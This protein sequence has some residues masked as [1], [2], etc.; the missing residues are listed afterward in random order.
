M[1]VQIGFIGAGSIA[2]THAEALAPLDVDIVAVADVDTETRSAFAEE[3]D[4]GATYEDYQRMLDEEALDGG[5]V[6]VPNHL[7]ADCAVACLEAGIH[8]FVE[9]PLAHT[10]EAGRRIA[11]AEASS[12]ATVFVGFT[13]TFKPTVESVKRR[14][15]DDEFGDIYDVGIEYVRRRGIPQ[16]GS[17]FTQ[18]SKAG[19]G[20]LIDCGVHLLALT[21]YI[22]DYPEIS[23]VSA[24]TGTRFGDDPEYTYLNM[25]GGDPTP[26]RTCTVEDTVKALLRTRDGTSIR[27]DCAWASNREPRRSVQLLGDETGTTLGI[28]EEDATLFTTEYGDIVESTLQVADQDPFQAEWQYFN[29]VITGDRAHTR[30]TVEEGLAVQRILDAVYRSGDCEAEV[31]PRLPTGK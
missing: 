21:L 1:S 28:H 8:A 24:T 12:S 26:D 3:Y 15:D 27:V 4:I 23:T 9:K 11:R 7:H 2:E 17:W 31:S 14:V 25:W 30:N 20:A 6:A 10:L 29:G 13:M 5:L 19:G 22:L 18:K 16:L